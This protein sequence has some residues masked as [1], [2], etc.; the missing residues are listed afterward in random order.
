ML[1]RVDGPDWQGTGSI[2]RN[3]SDKGKD[4]ASELD[5]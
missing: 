5:N 2:T 1:G 4:D 3:C